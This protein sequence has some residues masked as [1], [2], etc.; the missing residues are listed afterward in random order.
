MVYD[1]RLFMINQ[2]QR[3]NDVFEEKRRFFSRY[4][5]MFLGLLGVI[6]LIGLGSYLYWSE[7]SSDVT[8]DVTEEEATEVMTK[9]FGEL[10]RDIKIEKIAAIEPVAG[11]PLVARTGGRVSSIEV[12]LGEELTAGRVV[13]SID[14]GVEASPGRAQLAAIQAS[15]GQINGI[16]AEAVRAGENGVKMAQLAAEAA[17]AGR[18]LTTLQ[19]A[20][21]Q[22]Q[23]DLAVRQAELAYN[24]AA[25]AEQRVDQVV[26]AADIGLKAAKLAQEQA[27][28]A[29][30]VAARQTSDGLKQAEQG[31]AAAKQTIDKIHVDIQAQRVSL[32]R[33]VAV[34]AE[35]V[36]LAQVISPV[37]GQ[38]TRLA[39][40]KGD[41][42]RPGQ[43]VG[44]VIAFE[45]AQISLNVA[46]GVR[47]SLAVNDQVEI[48]ARG[49]EFSGVIA[50]LADA[51]RT[52][53]ALW[54]V[55]IF[56]S[57]TPEVVHP[58]DLVVVKLPVTVGE[59]DNHFIP[60]DAVVVRQGGIVLMTVNEQG[61]VEERIVTPISYTDNY[62]EAKLEID[63]NTV[64][65]IQGQRI[66]RAGDVV[67][68]G[69]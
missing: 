9:T 23:A 4:K 57:G 54:Q 40:R 53:M 6:V 13:V 62:M 55:D 68:L 39:V 60:L 61:V 18:S 20:K 63:D 7:K 51:P 19:L 11:A 27:A 66:L 37:D 15:L 3:Y 35:Q 8:G 59:S 31:V 64:V 56:V 69:S 36:K 29:Q 47:E 25:E 24:D 45:G 30:K 16:E 17:K 1:G 2:N 32:Q 67:K 42:V 5:R 48:S 10:V 33:Q 34:A 58:G 38:V 49:Q 21:S 22:E 65:I 14:T 52:D 41:F 43:E 28:I 44:E 50:R 26:R 46:T 12:N